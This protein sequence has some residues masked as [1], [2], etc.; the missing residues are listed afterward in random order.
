MEAKGLRQPTS[1]AQK[2]PRRLSFHVV[3][4]Y[5]ARHEKS[6][7]GVEVRSIA[8]EI[9]VSRTK[10]NDLELEIASLPEQKITKA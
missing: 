8:V 2:S 10:N 7:D 4:Q 6:L 5:K 1:E 3:Q 9:I